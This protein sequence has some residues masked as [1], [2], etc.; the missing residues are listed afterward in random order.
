MQANNFAK[1]IG[2]VAAGMVFIVV[3]HTATDALL[4]ANGILPKGNLHV[5]AGLIL[6]VLGYRA[7]FSVAGCYLTARLAP[8][9]PLKHSLILGAI[10][11]VMSTLGAIANEKL[12]LGPSWY[13]WTLVAI[14]LPL[15]WLGGRLYQL[16]Y[17]KRTSA[18][19]RLPR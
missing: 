12:N 17:A 1:S 19:T 6:L 3:T 9:R 15:A 13:T 7:V 18:A 14:S 11:L 16:Q 4:E 5:G 10:G 2:A 8:Q